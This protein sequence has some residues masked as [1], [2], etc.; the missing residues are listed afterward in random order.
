MNRCQ[1]VWIF[2]ARNN[3]VYHL[4]LAYSTISHCRI[5]DLFSYDKYMYTCTH[6]WNVRF[7]C[8]FRTTFC[9]LVETC[10]NVIRAFRKMF[11]LLAV[12]S[13]GA[14]LAVQEAIKVSCLNHLTNVGFSKETESTS[15]CRKQM[16]WSSITFFPLAEVLLA[17]AAII[18]SLIPLVWVWFSRC[19]AYTDVR[20]SLFA[21]SDFQTQAWCMVIE[22]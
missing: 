9:I 11:I 22:P 19:K 2:V 12:Y 15:L 14:A 18:L 3:K 17:F 20:W 8:H 1:L 21:G 4:C 16:F 6:R 7:I 5:P 10:R 13:M